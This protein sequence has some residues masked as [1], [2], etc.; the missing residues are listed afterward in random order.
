MDMFYD[1]DIENITEKYDA[2]DKY[3]YVITDNSVEGKTYM[4][5]TNLV[6]FTTNGIKV[7]PSHYI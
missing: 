3:E 5:W 4:T 1:P 7:L 2:I 6:N